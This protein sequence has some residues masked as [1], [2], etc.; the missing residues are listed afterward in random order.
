MAKAQQVLILEPSSEL[1]FK[2]PF[3]EYVNANLTLT[4]PSPRDVYFKVK[5][6]APKFY[7]VRPN[8]GLI[9]AE[10]KAQINVMLQPVESPETLES[11]RSRHKFMIQSAFAPE[12]EQPPVDQFWKSISSAQ[13]M[14]SKLRVVFQRPY[15]LNDDAAKEN[16]ES[17]LNTMASTAT[18][19][20]MNAAFNSSQNQQAK[21]TSLGSA[22]SSSTTLQTELGDP[23]AALQKEIE[24]RKMYQD[25]KA[26]LEKENYALL[27]KMEKLAQASSSGLS[28]SQDNIPMLH[29]ILFAFLALLLG[30]IVGKLL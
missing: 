3:T 24:L 26:N 23:Q 11:E 16:Y 2:G 22:R 8:S 19:R 10:D 13:I 6:T 18:T 5:T 27:E 17:S 30:L 25:E 15:G 21:D 12:G 14:D 20:A 7:C 1:T 28:M 9:K 4:N 29:A